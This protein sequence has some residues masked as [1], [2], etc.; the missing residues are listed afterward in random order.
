MSGSRS[1]LTVEPEYLPLAGL[2]VYAGLSV[3]TL[4]TYLA[5][6]A[7]PLPCYKIGG[8]VRVR[9]ADYDAW[10]LQFRQV[11]DSR[12]DALVQ[13]ALHGH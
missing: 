11:S 10:A 1:S 3:R 4:R 5:H 2:A 12:V 9:R 13:D 7:F 8:S 6:P